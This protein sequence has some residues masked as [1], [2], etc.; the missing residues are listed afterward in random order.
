MRTPI[1]TLSAL[2]VLLF[3][4]SCD[5]QEE[6]LVPD[7]TAPP[8]ATI[9]DIVVESYV[10]RTYISVLG[11]KADNQ[12]FDQAFALLRTNNLAEADRATFVNGILG[13]D[14]YYDNQFDVARTLHLNSVDTTTIRDQIFIFQIGLSDPAQSAF[15]DIYQA[16]IDRLAAVLASPT[17]LKAGTIGI[18]DMH[19]RLAYNYVYDQINM[20]TQN[21]VISMFQNFLFRY[22]TEAERAASET[23]VD[24][25]PSQIFLATGRSKDDFVNIFFQSNDY[26][27]GQVRDVFSRF[28]FREPDV[29]EL[30][31]LS[32]DYQQSNDFEA[33]MRAVL[34]SDEFVGL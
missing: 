34:T 19:A 26:Y 15:H 25:F 12:E 9:S 4:W 6:V 11:R 24:G 14:A 5:S 33:L 29:E 8:D 18:R 21:F 3:V 30:E 2:F 1:A 22:P 13:S 16:E 28:L 32:V 20:G 7:N 31:T 23:M 10:N 17:E 27:E